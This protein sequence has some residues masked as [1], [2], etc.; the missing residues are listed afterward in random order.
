MWTRL[1]G[2]HVKSSSQSVCVIQRTT[3]QSELSNTSHNLIILREFSRSSNDNDKTYYDVLNVPED[4]EQADIKNS[5][6][7]LSKLYHPD[8]NSNKKADQ[9]ALVKSQKFREI[10]EAYEVLGN[11]NAREEYNKGNIEISKYIHI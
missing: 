8:R 5:Y 3:I 11:K 2:C 10:T 7:E 9:N 6:Y 1:L 4:A